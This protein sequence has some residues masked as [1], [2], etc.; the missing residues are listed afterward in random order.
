M[1]YHI[2]RPADHSACATLLFLL[3]YADF[4]D[5]SPKDNSKNPSAHLSSTM[6][7]AE[8]LSIPFFPVSPASIKRHRAR[9]N[10]P[11]IFPFDFGSSSPAAHRCPSQ[12]NYPNDSGAHIHKLKNAVQN[13]TVRIQRDWY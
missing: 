10:I 1:S 11:V 3:K 8:K 12:K 9:Q 2:S 13:K 6:K 4:P 5:K 7:N